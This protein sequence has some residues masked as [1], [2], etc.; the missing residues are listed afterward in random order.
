MPTRALRYQCP[1]GQA[2]IRVT[3]LLQLTTRPSL[4]VER[5][6]CH[7]DVTMYTESSHHPLCGW[8]AAFESRPIATLRS[9]RSARVLSTPPIHSA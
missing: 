8:Y 4:S 6:N 1:V 5:I 2:C 7:Q 9:Q 3:R